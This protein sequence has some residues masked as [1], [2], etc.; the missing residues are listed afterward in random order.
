MRGKGRSETDERIESWVVVVV[1]VV[2]VVSGSS[3][4]PFVVEVVEVII[5]VKVVVEVQSAGWHSS[6]L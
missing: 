4:C 3:R 6:G 1:V 5:V 2:V